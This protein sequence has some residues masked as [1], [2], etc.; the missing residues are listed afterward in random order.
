MAIPTELYNGLLNYISLKRAFQQSRPER[1]PTLPISHQSPAQAFLQWSC[2]W[3]R[4]SAFLDWVSWAQANDRAAFVIELS[5][6]SVTLG[7]IKALFA[8]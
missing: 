8:L 5:A 7:K 2:L 6:F 3:Q 1:L 4:P